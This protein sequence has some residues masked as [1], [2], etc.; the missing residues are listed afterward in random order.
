MFF[1]WTNCRISHRI[2]TKLYIYTTEMATG[3]FKLSNHVSHVSQLQGH[4][5]LFL[6][7]SSTK[8]MFGS[9]EKNK[10]KR[11]TE[12]LSEGLQWAPSDDSISNS[13][14][15]LYIF[16]SHVIFAVYSFL[17]PKMLQPPIF[18]KF[19]VTDTLLSSIDALLW[20]VGE[21]TTIRV[22]TCAQYSTL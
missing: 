15:C 14:F 11:N 16:F 17:Q 19:S 12:R 8:F 10:K 18:L 22:F 7:R 1:L 20:F 13:V 21:K 5:E 6:P 2:D 9:S 3:L 4:E